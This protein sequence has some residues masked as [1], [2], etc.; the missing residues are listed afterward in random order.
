MS[1]I[2][3]QKQVFFLP[4]FSQMANDMNEIWQ[5]SVAVG[6]TFVVQF[7]PARCICGSRSNDNDTI[8]ERTRRMLK[9]TPAGPFPIV[10]RIEEEQNNFSGARVV[11]VSVALFK[12]RFV[13]ACY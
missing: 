10:T 6:N 12:L 4:P 2:V 11:S 9:W 5:E 1:S 13:S 7:H 3:G 8:S